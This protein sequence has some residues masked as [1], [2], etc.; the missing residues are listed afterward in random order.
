MGNT[1]TLEV[2]GLQH[3]IVGWHQ[4][5]SVR[6]TTEEI[7]GWRESFAADA[8]AF[9]VAG[10]TSA[11]CKAGAAPRRVTGKKGGARGRTKR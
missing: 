7:A 6:W 5:Y 1:Y 10:C 8:G 11:G 3:L 9:K 4:R 2:A